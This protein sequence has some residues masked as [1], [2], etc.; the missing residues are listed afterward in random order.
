MRYTDQLREAAGDQWNRVI[1]HKFTKDLAAGTI[2]H[3]C[4]KKYLI[5]DHR[6]LDSGVV[7]FASMIAKAKT[8]EDRIPGCQFLALLTGKENTYFERSFEALK[9]SQEERS[10]IP[11]A[12]CTTEFC[13]FVLSVAAT[14]SLA[15]MLAVI[16]ACEW[17]Y[18]SWGELVLEEHVRKDFYCYEWVDLHSGDYFTSVVEYLRSLLDKEVE[19]MNDAEKKACQ[20]RFLE[21]VQLEEDFFDFAMKK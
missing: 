16:V 19:T 12:A 15:E 6:F 11:N 20:T 3:D 10:S 2:D 21:T 1:H 17:S 13:D 14:G 9:V 8:L 18:L 5:Q 7:L 4:L